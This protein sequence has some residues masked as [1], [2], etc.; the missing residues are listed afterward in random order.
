[1][2]ANLNSGHD[3]S[4][5][6]SASENDRWRKLCAGY[7]PV[8]PGNSIWRYSRAPGKD[9]PDQGWK[10]HISATILTANRV[11]EK[12]A[13]YLKGCGALFK[14]P[15][16]LQEL[17]KINSGLHY[18]YSQIGKFITVYPK[19]DKEAVSLARHLHKLTR[20]MRAPA[21]PF[22]LRL[23]SDSC[24]YY[25]YGSFSHLEIENADGTCTP[26]MRGRDGELVPDE[27]YS[28][29]A[30]PDWVANPF[31]REQPRARNSSVESP[32]K[33]TFRAFQ[34][35]AQRGKG[36]VYKALDFSAHPPRLCILKEG[37]SDGEINWDERDGYW[38]VKHEEQVLASLQAAG[39]EVPAVQSSFESQN[40]YYL[41]T[42]FIEGE[43]LQEFLVKRKR[44]LPVSRALNYGIQLS[45]LL[46]RIHSAN[47]AWRDCKPA[48][49][50][51][52]KDGKLRPVDFEGACRLEEHG[53][54]IWSTPTFIP[55][56]HK[57]GESQ[58]S[59]KYDDLYA[60]GVVIYLLLT[61]QLPESSSQVPV[62]KLRRNVPQK[63][64][65]LVE[66]L[67]HDDPRRRPGAQNIRR[68]LAAAI[69]GM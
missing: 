58:L 60:L 7:L 67:L 2:I 53:S 44:R 11:L 21:V 56:E 12:I 13:P 45:A 36:G 22:D 61:G 37:R 4:R 24:I 19:S 54:M 27:R 9:D 32:L 40:N 14:A 16:S 31:G 3:A 39:V 47:W 25:R 5:A 29:T 64:C 33:T 50:I 59:R 30:M 17:Q 15:R 38:M 63:V 68:R 42:E 35:L 43:S 57:R 48:N 52:T 34:A 41:V 20:R 6:L 62:K 65:D 49:L 8:D 69:S 51:L 23:Q 10:L 18:G 28:E 1:M 55:P 46:S 26:A 66:E